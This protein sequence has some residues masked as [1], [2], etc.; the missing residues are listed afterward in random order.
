MAIVGWWFWAH[1]V[2]CWRL[3]VGRW[4]QRAAEATTWLNG[5][6]VLAVVAYAIGSALGL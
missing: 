5:L 6:I 2:V 3:P 1:L 4:H